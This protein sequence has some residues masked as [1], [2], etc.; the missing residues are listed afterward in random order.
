[1]DI[2]LI[3]STVPEVAQFSRDFPGFDISRYDFFG[4]SSGSR[5]EA[6]LSASDELRETL[7]ACQRLARIA[8]SASA[9]V[10]LKERG[11]TS[12]AQVAGLEE[13]HFVQVCADALG[14]DAG[15]ARTIHARARA[16]AGQTIH[17]WANAAALAKSP[18]LRDS[19]VS[20]VGSGVGEFF[21]GLPSYEQLFGNQDYC[22]CEHCQSIFGPA[23]YFVDLMRLTQRYVTEPNRAT[24]PA[25]MTL[26][27]RR[28]R[29]FTMKLSCAA[30]NDIVPH[31]AIANGVLADWVV[32]LLGTDSPERYLASASYPFN[33]P[34][35]LPLVETRGLLAT[36]GLSLEQVYTAFRQPDFAT[37]VAVATADSV[38]LST[39][40]PEG[41]EMVGAVVRMVAGPGLG[42]ARRIT[43]YDAA[44]RVAGVGQPWSEPATATSECVVEWQ[45]WPALRETLGLS[46]EQAGLASTAV[47]DPAA[48]AR[49]YG[50][51]QG[52][53]LGVLSAMSVFLH[54]AGFDPVGL[55]TLLF[56]DLDETEIEAGLP[57]SLFINGALAGEAY[58]D[59]ET[60]ANGVERL[61]HL[62][63]P[64][65]DRIGRFVR[66]SRWS[67]LSFADL[68]WLIAA[69]GET[70]I[71]EGT[72]IEI[73]DALRARAATGLPID[74]L[75]S[76]WSDLKTIGRGSGEQPADLFD[77]IWNAIGLLA[78]GGVYRPRY[79]ANKLFVD[80]VV[81]WNVATGAV[82][83][84]T[85]GR[86]RLIAALQVSDSELTGIGK[87]LFGAG[88]VPLDVANLTLLYRTT[89][90]MKLARLDL[91]AYRRLLAWLGLG[92][93]APFVPQN[94]IRFLAAARWMAAARLPS[95]AVAF[96]LDGAV[97]TPL[98]TPAHA[99]SYQQMRSLW[100]LA[101]PAYLTPQSFVADTIT[102]E[103]SAE[104]YAAVRQRTDPVLIRSLAADYAKVF[105]EPQ[106]EL[107]MVVGSVGKADLAFLEDF[108]FTARQI[109]TIA[110]A[111]NA[112][113]VAEEQLLVDQL[114]FM[115][116][117]NSAMIAA[118]TSYLGAI[119][120]AP[121]L[122][123]TLLTPTPETTGVAPSAQWQAIET[124]FLQLSRLLVA[125]AI[126]PID[127]PTLAAMARM[128]AVFG[129]AD[130]ETPTLQDLRQVHAYNGLVAAFGAS[131]T[132]F[133]DYFAM[134]AA[135]A[136]EQQ[137]K[138]ARL[139]E[140][141]GWP[142]PQIVE[143]L[144][145]IGQTIALIDT[146]AGVTRLTQV[147]AL[148][149]A[150]GFDP[151]FAQRLL[152]LRH[153]PADGPDD[154]HANW[155]VYLKTAAATH[156]TMAGKLGP[157]WDE[158]YANTVSQMNMAR[159]DA[160]EGLVVW[161]LGRVHPWI[162]D[163]RQLYGFLLIDVEMSGCAATS[164]VAEAIGAVQLY[165]QRCR[166]NLEPGVDRLNVPEVWWE[167][168]T[169]YRVW[170][171][172]RK[173]FLYPENY[174]E[175]TLRS[176]RTELFKELQESLLQTNI[177]AD[178]VTA[179]YGKYFERLDGL[180]TLIYVD[181]LRCLFD[182]QKRAP[183]ETMFAFARTLAEPYKFY[184]AKQELG[185]VWSEWRQIDASIPSPY[186]APAYAFGRLFI[187][188][189][190]LNVVREIKIRSDKDGSV[191][192]NNSTFSSSIR[193]SFQTSTGSWSPAQSLA[194]EE[195]AYVT[196]AKPT[197][198]S[199]SGYGLFDMNALFWRKC[200]ALTVP[201]DRLLAPPLATGRD[202]KLVIFYGPFLENNQ[203]PPSPLTV[204][205]RPD[206]AL[207][208]QEPSR[209]EFE[210]NA[211]YRS[212]MVNQAI[213]T[214]TR[215]DV[216]LQSARVL[217][218][219]LH[220]DFLMRSSEFRVLVQ[221]RSPGVPPAMTPIIDVATNAL[222]V[223]DTLN[224]L[225]SNYYGD[226][227]PPIQS[228]KQA[229]SAKNE[230]FVIDGV[231]ATASQG[232]Y[233]DLLGHGVI[234]QQGMVDPTFTTNTDLHFLFGGESFHNREIL[235]AEI[236]NI[237]LN[238]KARTL[239]AKGDSFLLTEIDATLA[240]QV[241]ADL[242]GHGVLDSRDRVD[243]TLNSRTNLSFLFEGAPPE[244]QERLIYEVR[245][246]LFRLMADP[247]LLGSVSRRNSAT[248]MTKNQPDWFLINTGN[249]AFKV[250]TADMLM[251]M[252]SANLRVKEVP[253]VQTVTTESFITPNIDKA[254]SA[255]AYADLLG[256]GVIN[257]QGQLDRTFGPTTDLSFLFVN[258]PARERAIM[259][260]EVRAILLNL[261]TI[262]ALSYFYE[263]ND[264]VFTAAALLPLGIGQ[265]A[266]DQAYAAL[267]EHQVVSATGVVSRT[268]G[269]ATDL[270]FL[271]PDAGARR[272]LLILETRAILKR[273]YA[274]TWQRTL[275]DVRFAFERLT[276]AAVARLNASLA[277]GGVESLLKLASQ[278]APVV[279]LVPFSAYL[280]TPKVVPPPL[281]DG[282]QVDFNGPYGLYYWELFYFTPDLVAS[283]LL[284]SGRYAEAIAWLQYIFNPTVRPDPLG[285]RDFITPDI[286][287]AEAI[288]ADAALREKGII[289]PDG[290]VASDFGPQTDLSFLF[291]QVTDPARRELM[292]R[293]VRNVLN[294][295]LMAAPTSRFWQFMPFR[296]QTLQSLVQTLTDPATIAIYE[297]DPFDPYAIARLRIG[298]FEKSTVMTY[299]NALIE[300]GDSLYAQKTRESLT[301]A[302][303]LYLYA[304]EL[305]GPRPVDEGPCKT[306]APASYAE[307]AE[308]Y[309]DVPGGIPPFL[310]DL[311]NVVSPDQEF[312]S[313][314]LLGQPF[315]DVEALFC[316]P[317]N[318]KML[319]Y[320]DMVADRLY[321]LRN[322]LDL[323][324]N[325]L[326]LPLFAPPLDPMA[327]VRSAAAGTS[328]LVVNPQAQAAVPLYRY[329]YLM[330]Q[331][332]TIVSSA[333]ILGSALSTALMERDNEVLLRL[334]A[335]Q[336]L[337]ILNLTTRM[338]TLQVDEARDNLAALQQS[339]AAIESRRDF[340]NRQI[341]EF[342]SPNEV[343]NITLSG[344]ALGTSVAAGIAQTVAAIA[345]AAPQVGAPTAMT[346]GGIQL[347]NSAS[348]WAAALESATKG[349]EFG[350][351]TALTMAGY[352]RR[353]Q[354]WQREV[355][356]SGFDLAQTE[357]QIGAAQAQLD[358]ALR[359]LEIH[360]RTIA[361]SQE[362]SD[363]L[364]RKFDNYELFAWSA[365]RLSSLFY[366]TYRAALEA[367]LAAQSAYQYELNSDDVFVS[368]APWDERHY[369]LLSGET[370]NMALDQMDQAYVRNNKRRL[371]ITKTVSLAEVAPAE[372]LRLRT[373]GRCT[374]NITEAMFDFDFPGHYC[375]R[376]KTAEFSL[377]TSM[378]EGASFEIHASILQTRN[379]ILVRAD[380]AG[381]DYMLN[382]GAE[383][384]LSVRSNWQSN[385]AIAD[386]IS[387]LGSGLW[388]L[389]LGIDDRLY[390]FEGTGAVCTFDLSMPLT[391]NRFD[392]STI[393]D[394]QVT[395]RYS[396]LDGGTTFRKDVQ[397]ALSGPVFS[398]HSFLSLAADFPE[399]WTSFMN[400][401]D[402]PG[403]QSLSIDIGLAQLVPNLSSYLLD[404]VDVWITVPQ[405]EPLP[406]TSTFLNLAPARLEPADVTLRGMVG[407]YD[408]KGALLDQFSGDWVITVDLAAMKKVP[409]LA[410]LLV[411]GFLNPAKFLDIGLA[412]N[413]R[414]EVFKS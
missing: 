57:H 211:Y 250:V 365:G 340:Y 4:K 117:S 36:A 164:L 370:L 323:E 322:C 66:L 381:L 199:E 253:S 153:L 343:A 126:L 289:L 31:L 330:I 87:M 192:E 187:F 246:V 327:L 51:P 260:A 229:A 191:S 185:A 70:E 96:V 63:P 131:G 189:V 158:T 279:P 93:T 309:K 1:M 168:M 74:M 237:L 361:Q 220:L 228:A 262:T 398:G 399:A 355:D 208:V 159:R 354:D 142:A 384:P 328:G 210:L 110:D 291:P 2:S 333:T 337:A 266:A 150:G 65:L 409:A 178:T 34:Q 267:V 334:R 358:S 19:P 258:A 128:P 269:P 344:I 376:I 410:A 295:N 383:P 59:I 345:Y 124:L 121:A 316:V 138:L 75:T 351:Q 60:D 20:P 45:D 41:K 413:Y 72:L 86:S 268:Y 103:R 127:A 389:I 244:E 177:T 390:P 284:R 238:L 407:H 40:P 94:V 331:A 198:N 23:A 108:G 100:L 412:L 161:Q 313:P 396:A 15:L 50:L 47:V 152:A 42:Q 317:E 111:M 346:Y 288:E 134:P 348:K 84:G 85:F 366:Q 406:A 375:R 209:Y 367:T 140:L 97:P 169:N 280:P 359:D 43:S 254:L 294:N 213:S 78:D 9:L 154:T 156:G 83:G 207:K 193:F 232:V 360:Q 385:Q 405:G 270:S 403:A 99:A 215:G 13:G 373:E 98:P 115:F 251:P 113:L 79:P 71:G 90:L 62:D 201:G 82:S 148:F 149:A 382:G 306:E 170:E 35:N 166:L 357:K 290:M 44:T 304:D 224:I 395:L 225:K 133:L 338:K 352:Q 277:S 379:D 137:A 301:A 212:G 157:T 176:S 202:E 315:N 374:I 311:E 109:A 218:R 197:F 28:P 391:T 119:V 6:A 52:T 151:G 239:P 400:G 255:Q 332:R 183:I 392:F 32:K 135:T 39:A 252:L 292:I 325:A 248:I 341:A 73:A 10:A 402:D 46:I 329:A 12:A 217:N 48:L 314:A 371:E 125:A 249:E 136:E 245:R 321:K 38:T 297:N 300:W 308:R 33:L 274:A 219:D 336:E 16:I 233:N 14:G 356:Q 24:I 112:V 272:D 265:T 163:A 5:V 122:L 414:A 271:Y 55:Q 182:D 372:L 223:G 194:P 257:A 231:D 30:T 102:P 81:Q 362:N 303:M 22:S 307:I 216:P 404:G 26:E 394:V 147:F 141:T 286:S 312:A 58:V 196:T 368:F 319:S 259:T 190:E 160:L 227:T 29:L 114:A 276:T 64:T 17:L 310:I 302:T 282:A 181:S 408:A 67:G 349:L 353:A 186:I 261:P 54:Q 3:A 77:R 143:V 335:S 76:L 236:Q 364:L 221:N 318:E 188:W 129:I 386:S 393:G 37:G 132:E 61:T 256:A 25:G 350:A 167:W 324:G 101:R 146:V 298:A 200:S 243:P 299:L 247:L 226:W 195:V 8:P 162:Q 273:F 174:M 18:L 145:Q 287:E 387:S 281:F 49:L 339:K 411:D 116:G 80:D 27:E 184:V 92:P 347:G 204:P 378:D 21:S 397:K 175:P 263:D 165:L 89:L 173:V 91:A 172:N 305:L 118:A 56:E 69:A 275:H 179:A 53:D 130:L 144:A 369:G 203:D 240:A 235:V 171:A 155:D 104:A 230:D 11:F 88:E 283:T 278:Q 264:T 242:R 241:M 180:A 205:A 285:P 320:W 106:S 222:H 95:D 123:E 377:V 107:A 234:D 363:F 388:E 326:S 206:P 380:P 342:M 7:M 293:E 401:H 296:N 214:T 120:G 139:A 68:N 105:I